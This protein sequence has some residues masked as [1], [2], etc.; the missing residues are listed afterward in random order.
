M[1]GYDMHF[2]KSD[3]K[4]ATPPRYT[5]HKA[6]K[7]YGCEIGCGTTINPG[8]LYRRS[9]RSLQIICIPCWEK[10]WPTT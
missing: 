6:S 10:K 2:G 9:K 7:S 4:N 3:P 5:E 8:E 1:A